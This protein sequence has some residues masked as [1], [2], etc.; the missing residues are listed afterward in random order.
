MLGVQAM[1][2]RTL[3]EEDD[4]TRDG[5][6]VAV[7][8]YFWWT[9]SLARDP[10]VLNK[11]LRIGRPSSRSSVSSEEFLGPRLG[12]RRI[13]GFLCRCR[14]RFRQIS[15]DTATIFRVA[16]LDGAAETRRE[17]GQAS[18]DANLLYQQILRGFPDAPLSRENL[19]KLRQT[20]LT[21][22]DGHWVVT[23][24]RQFSDP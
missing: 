15:M 11:K 13:S 24:R 21:D 4:R 19:E 8:S 22:S 18:A 16:V 12:N 20:R 17:H 23:L 5:N 2:G 6:P 9:R 1:A 7:V 10:S 3:T 14:R